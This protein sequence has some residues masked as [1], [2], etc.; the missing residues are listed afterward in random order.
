MKRFQEKIKDLVENPLYEAVQNHKVD[1]MATLSA[2]RF[3]DATAE[4]MAKWLDAIADLSKA[5]GV[6]RALAGHRGVGKSHFL[7]VVGALAERPDLR[8]KITDS[9]VLASSER[10]QR[11]KF[12]VVHV[13][14]GTCETLVEEFQIALAEAFHNS[15]NDWSNQPQ[16]MVA[17]AAEQNPEP[18][19]FLIDSAYNRTQKVGRDDGIT[20]GEI[21]EEAKKHKIFIAVA[22]DDDIAGADGVNA[23]IVRTYAIDYLDQEHL[24]RIVESFLYQKRLPARPLLRELYH[25]LQS[26]VSGFNW[27]EQ[28]FAALYPI[29]PVVADVTPAVRMYAQH[30]AFLPFAASVSAKVMNRPA[31][32]LVALDELFDRVE[33]DLRKSEDLQEVFSHYDVLI[34]QAISQIPVMQRMQAKLIL[35]GL[36]ILSLDGR[37]ANARELSAAMLIYD[38]N[39]PQAA[40]DRINNTLEAFTNAAPSEVLQKYDEDDGVRYA[41]TVKASASFESD[42]A[43]FAKSVDPSHLG[44]IML[45]TSQS[46]F[47]DFKTVETE[48]RKVTPTSLQTDFTWHGGIRRGKVTW[49]WN[50]SENAE[51]AEN[52]PEE[53]NAEWELFICPPNEAQGFSRAFTR[54]TLIWEPAALKTEEIQTLRRF[55]VLCTNIELIEKYSE[56]TI[57]AQQTYTALV[58]RIWTRIFLEESKFYD[59]N[60]EIATP[61]EAI[62]ASSVKEGLSAL[63]APVFESIYPWHPNFENTLEINNLSVLVSEFFGGGDQNAPAIQEL[64]RVFAAPLGLVTQRGSHYLL[65]TE[66]NMSSQPWVREIT[67]MVA[68]AENEVVPIDEIYLRLRNTPYGLTREAQYLVLAALVAHRRYEFVT[69]TGERI[70]RRSLNL[71]IIWSEIA[72]IARSVAALREAAELTLWAK[73]LTGLE[74]VTSLDL[75]QDREKIRVSLVEWL[76]KWHVERVSEKF[77]ALPDEALNTQVWRIAARAQKSFGAVAE[78]VEATIDNVISL[79][80]GLQRVADAFADSHEEFARNKQELSEFKSFLEAASQ[81]VSAAKYLSLAELTS[82]EMIEKLRRSLLEM[83]REPSVFLAPEAGHLFSRNWAEFQKLYVEF[84]SSHHDSIM[85]NP[86]FRQAIMGI[87]QSAEWEE[88]EFLSYFPIFQQKFWQKAIR[89]RDRGR[90]FGCQFEVREVLQKHSSCACGFRLGRLAQWENLP[91]ELLQTMNLGRQSYRQTLGLVRQ[92]LVGIFQAIAERER[93]PQLADRARMLANLFAGNAEFPL[94]TRIDLRL[95]EQA[96]KRLKIPSLDVTAPNLSLMT[97]E[98]LR[99]RLN[100]WLD[101]LPNEP[102][103]I[104]LENDVPDIH[105]DD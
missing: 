105:S 71:R 97:R 41:L 30:F 70:G 101:D 69:Y 53:G 51:N 44:N 46:H 96:V 94:L 10:L 6:A 14:R 73:T 12:T 87:L 36:L 35:K 82:D 78:A 13:E 91:N 48:S 42:L 56:A 45:R 63:F 38:E 8:S 100:R 22:L 20:L 95:L 90:D 80:E 21:G 76:D 32:S 18:I 99:V 49:L 60:G 85:K 79:N 58:E 9:Y 1:L 23:S 19:I 57:A 47:A 83:L 74:D 2:Y 4:L 33:P 59:E 50:P 98:E 77:E 34:N 31:H 28:R 62:I 84:Y 67:S 27:S 61:N 55:Y 103:L 15:K 54:P 72:G 66:D 29:H 37:G 7:S 40:I 86:N 39:Q 89:L 65:E 5:G 43:H 17:L 81:R 92:S 16:A 104:N 24:Y 3:T 25:S 11:R 93:I 52:T 88:F 102:A 26:V 68:N 64:A 75:P